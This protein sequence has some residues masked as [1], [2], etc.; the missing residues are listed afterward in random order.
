M[1]T[2]CSYTVPSIWIEAS[3]KLS[4]CIHNSLDVASGAFLRRE[5]GKA[6]QHCSTSLAA[7]AGVPPA[8]PAQREPKVRPAFLALIC[9]SAGK[10]RPENK[11]PPTARRVLGHLNAN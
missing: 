9:T 7:T 3:E 11:S 2:S 4:I 1:R 10:S 8:A 5:D 6:D